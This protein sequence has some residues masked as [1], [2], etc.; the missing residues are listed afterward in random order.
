VTV[1]EKQGLGL[2][3]MPV[4]ALTISVVATIVSVAIVL[5]LRRYL[6]R[7]DRQIRRNLDADLKTLDAEL[8]HIQTKQ[9]LALRQMQMMQITLGRLA[10]QANPTVQF[11][12]QA[13]RQGS[14][15][16][17]RETSYSIT[18][19]INNIEINWPV[20]SS[21]DVVICAVALGTEYREI[22]RPCLDSHKK[23]AQQHGY[24]YAVL[25]RP[26][27]YPER[28]HPWL[29]LPLILRLFQDG[30]KKV[31]YID[32]DAMITNTEISLDAY[33]AKF[34]HEADIFLTEDEGGINSG[35][36]F[37]VNTVGARRIFELIWLYDAD[38]DHD[39]WEQNAFKIIMNDFSEVRRKVL[40]EP[41]PKS[42]NSF[43][44]ERRLFHKTR[45]E[46]IWTAGD[47]ICHFSGI[48]SPELERYVRD[49][50]KGLSYLVVASDATKG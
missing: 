34:E 27:S 31:F 18:R 22:V 2:N 46:N 12:A 15:V 10:F 29:K 39:N 37:A 45:D 44:L 4:L 21:S 38:L 48:R 43:P 16:T 36:M 30:A 20:E 8:R 25:E 41:R 6:R 42:F 35:L 50:A 17:D 33:F 49:Y 19:L 11:L 40:I 9:D 7:I 3:F 26:P 1:S 14:P 5:T 24:R 13:L 47:F 23:Y 32:A 28:P